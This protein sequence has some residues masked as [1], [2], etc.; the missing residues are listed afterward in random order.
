MKWIVV[1]VCF[2]AVTLAIPLTPSED[3]GFIGQPIEELGSHFEGDILMTER[4]KQEIFDVMVDGK[5]G[6]L[7]PRYRWPNNILYY[8]YA[9]EV[10]QIQREY[11]DGALRNM[12]GHTCLSFVRRTDETDYVWVTTSDSGCY[13]YVGRVNGRQQLNLQNND[14]GLGCFR[15]GTVVHEFIHALG[16]HHTQTAYT[17]NDYVIIRWEFIQSGTEGNF[18]LR[19]RT[20]STMYD[21]DYDYDSVMHYG[22]TAFSINGQPTIVPT[23]EGAV[24]GQRNS[25]SPMDIQRLNRMYNCPDGQ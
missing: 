17:R 10:T 23:Q 3:N 9:D 24:F 6:L 14:P 7:N 16:F 18:V 15:F 1:L 22:P 19:D 21:L 12:S 5:T 4:Q 13:S 2:L 8:D 11:I 25:M 20:T